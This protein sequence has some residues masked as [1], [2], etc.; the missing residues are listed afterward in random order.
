MRLHR[1]TYLAMVAIAIPL[2]WLNLRINPE[3]RSAF[4]IDNAPNDVDPVTRFLF[5]RGWP[6]TPCM[7]CFLSGKWHPDATVQMAAFA[8]L[9][10]LIG[11]VI[12][13]GFIYEW[14]F[15]RR[16]GRGQSVSNQTR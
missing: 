16:H 12:I 3:A 4:N 5:F 8:D 11:G 14:Y 1:R 15:R 7:Y 13:V 2:V 9:L 10:I 6:F